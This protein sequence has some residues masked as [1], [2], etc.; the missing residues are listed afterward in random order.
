MIHSP[1]SVSCH[2]DAGLFQMLVEMN[3]LRRH[4]LRLDDALDAALLREAENVVLYGLG[5]AGAEDLGAAR[6]G[7]A[8]KLLGQFVEVRSGGGL[9]SGNLGAHCFEVD[10]FVG[11]GAADAVGRRKSCPALRKDSDWPGRREWIA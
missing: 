11:L 7:G 2:L 8:G 9:D 10:A 1:R 3:L 6:L 5:I 4:R